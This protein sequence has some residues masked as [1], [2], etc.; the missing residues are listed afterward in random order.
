MTQTQHEPHTL[1]VNVPSIP[2]GP[3]LPVHERDADYYRHAAQG[4]RHMT[5][6]GHGKF[7]GSNLTE[8]VAQLCDAAADA[9]IQAG[10]S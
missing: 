9:L 1:T 6:G 5:R 7:A 10:R 2:Y 8:A 3:D 4:I